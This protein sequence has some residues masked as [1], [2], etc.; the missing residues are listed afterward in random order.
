MA[1]VG[2]SGSYL[3]SSRPDE[4][5]EALKVASMSLLSLYGIH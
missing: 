3:S 4:V 1:T 2:G 5:S